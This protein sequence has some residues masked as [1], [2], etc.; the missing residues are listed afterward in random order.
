MQCSECGLLWYYNPAPAVIALIPRQGNQLLFTRR[1]F[2]PA[3]GKLDLPGGFADIFETIED[4]LVREVKEETGLRLLNWEFLKTL[5]NKYIYKD[6]LY[7]TLDSVFIC[8]ADLSGE[9]SPADD[10]SEIVWRN[11]LQVS[12]R[13][14][15]LGSIA[16]I[17]NEIQSTPSLFEKIFSK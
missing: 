5:P 17:V 1:K 14:V 7:Y 8:Q 11:P 9:A 16:K 4:T 2:E 3:K 10:V 6:L 13:E 12:I 15:G